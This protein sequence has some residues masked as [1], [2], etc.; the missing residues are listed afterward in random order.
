MTKGRRS[1]LQD[2]KKRHNDH[3]RCAPSSVSLSKTAGNP[4]DRESQFSDRQNQEFHED[5]LRIF[6]VILEQCL[7]GSN[8]AL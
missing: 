1:E 3:P 5:A 8:I 4:N 7:A 2:T 6:D